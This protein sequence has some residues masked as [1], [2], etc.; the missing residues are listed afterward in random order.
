MRTILRAL[1]P[2]LVLFSAGAAPLHALDFTLHR[3]QPLG[4]T[5][6]APKVYFTDADSKIYVEI[7]P[8]WKV[9]DSPQAL[10]CLPSRSNCRVRI[11]QTGGQPWVFDEVG[12][13]A[14]RKRVTAALPEGAK[15]V[16][17]VPDQSD[18]VPLSGWS[19]LEMAHDYEF[20][21]QQMRRGV[22]FLNLPEKRVLQVTITTPQA[23]FAAVQEQ[24]RLLLYG[25]FEP[26]KMLSPT[27]MKRYQ[28]GITD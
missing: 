23:D 9:T 1:I 16:Q 22:V 8:D 26:T 19:S 18:L 14:L 13:T 28:E 3:V 2:T 4:D 27:A 12:K 25:W 11:E 7:P 20:Y 17:A 15:N 10:D 24:T 21:G 5:R 6:Q